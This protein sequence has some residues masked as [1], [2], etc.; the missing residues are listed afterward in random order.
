[1]NKYATAQDY[2]KGMVEL[3][4]RGILTFGFVHRRLSGRDRGVGAQYI[5]LHPRDEIL[6]STMPSCISTTRSRLSTDGAR[7]SNRRSALLLAAPNDGLERGFVLDELAAEKRDE[8][9]STA[10]LRF[11][12]LVDSIPTG[13]MGSVSLRSNDSAGRRNRS[14][15]G[16][17][18]MA[19]NQYEAEF[20]TIRDVVAEWCQSTGRCGSQELRSEV[21]MQYQDRNSPNSRTRQ[22]GVRNENRVRIPWR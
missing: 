1:M 8:L 6:G 20:A 19:R 5:R 15:C 13:F 3:H 17:W 2:R 4:R 12:D 14:C 22:P 10:A 16:D 21:Q 9:H 7:S 11:F 18:T